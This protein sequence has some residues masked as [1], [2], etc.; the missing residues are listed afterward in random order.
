MA[1]LA[2]GENHEANIQSYRHHPDVGDVSPMVIAYRCHLRMHSGGE[3][4][5]TKAE[6]LNADGLVHGVRGAVPNESVSPLI[7]NP[8][9]ALDTRINKEGQVGG[10]K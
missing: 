8:I 1:L 10:L 2:V 4:M 9:D 5:K 6:I 3:L 7:L